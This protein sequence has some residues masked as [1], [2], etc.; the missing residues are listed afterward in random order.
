VLTRAFIIAITVA[1]IW[2]PLRS[3]GLGLGLG[4][5]IVESSLSSP[6][7]VDIPLRGMEGISLDPEKFSIV[8]EDASRPNMEYR[9]ERIDGDTATIVLY[10]RHMVT[11]PLVHFRLKVKWEKSA[12]ARSYDVFIDP[13]AYQFSTPD[14][15]VTTKITEVTPVEAP[16]PVAKEISEPVLQPV[17]TGSTVI[18]TEVEPENDAGIS[19]SEAVASEFSGEVPE[20][21]REYGPTIDGNSIWRV[22]RAVST[23]DKDLTIYQWMYGIWKANPQAFT[24]S[25]MHRLN[26]EEL[27]SIPLEREIAET[28]HSLAWRAYSSQM[29]MLQPSAETREVTPDD[30]PGDDVPGTNAVAEVSPGMA[31]EVIPVNSSSITTPGEST[32]ADLQETEVTAIDEPTIAVIENMDE[33]AMNAACNECSHHREPGGDRGIDRYRRGRGVDSDGLFKFR[34]R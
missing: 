26:M 25:N 31:D 15:V 9:L 18:V 3:F 20:Q 1:A 2:W 28:S 23:D 22:A 19:E 24:R 16:N 17:A 27:L 32:R 30:V 12:I 10:T 29:T 5:A 6:L 8:I 7:R 14:E 34:R 33:A 4:D 21:R 13:P 11:D